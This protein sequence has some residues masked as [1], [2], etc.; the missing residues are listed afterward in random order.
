VSR[1]AW[2]IVLLVAVGIATVYVWSA[3]AQLTG[4]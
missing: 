2:V 4:R 3:L 1:K